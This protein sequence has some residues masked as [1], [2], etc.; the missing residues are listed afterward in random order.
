MDDKIN[1]TNQ[2]PVSEFT[3]LFVSNPKVVNPADYGN[4]ED[5]HLVPLDDLLND[6][7]ET[8]HKK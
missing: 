2:N 7:E 5:F 3:S 8:K 4:Y 1:N 6:N